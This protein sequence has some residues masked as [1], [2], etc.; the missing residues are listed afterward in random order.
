MDTG[1]RGIRW[2]QTGNQKSAGEVGVRWATLKELDMAR[3]RWEPEGQLYV[4]TSGEDAQMGKEGAACTIIACV[5]VLS[6]TN[7]LFK[8][9]GEGQGLHSFAKRVIR[10]H[11]T[12]S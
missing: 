11:V 9:K 4:N 3:V 6:A 12:L 2:D 10:P 7:K 8:R 1:E 5:S